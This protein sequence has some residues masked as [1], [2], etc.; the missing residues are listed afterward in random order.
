MSSASDS[1]LESGR[2]GEQQ[3]PEKREPSPPPRSP[4]L[5]MDLDSGLVGWE[6]PDDPL[7]PKNWPL[8][9]KWKT[10]I[11]II[12]SCFM[13]PMTSTMFAP[14]VGDVIAEFG[15]TSSLRQTLLIS[16]YVL[17]F[18]W[19]PMMLHAPLSEL[20]GRKYVILAS[21]FCFSM[22]NL[23]CSLSRTSSAF[24]ACR[25][26]GG[27]LGSAGMVVGGGAIS[28][29]FQREKIGKVSSAFALGPLM[30]PNL[31][32]II[33]GFMTENVG[34]RW[35]FRLLLILGVAVSLLF[36]VLA[37]ESNPSVLLHYKTKKL[38]KQLQRPELISVY[39]IN[40]K[41]THRQVFWFGISRPL[42][43]LCT[44]PSVTFL[45]LYTAIAFSFLYIFLTTVPRIYHD[46]Y[47]FSP[48]IVG[49]CYLGMGA[50]QLAGIL[51]VGN[52]NDKLVNYLTK[53]NGGKR[54]PEFRLRPLFLSCIL[55]PVSMFWYG[56]AVEYRVHW[57]AVVASMFPLGLGMVAS[58]IPIQTYLIEAYAPFGLAA[59]ATAAGNC[60]RMT[61]GAFFPLVSAPLFNSLGHGWGCSLLGFL[62]LGLCGAM[63]IGFVYFGK[64]LR[65]RFP[66]RL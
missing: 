35:C 36:F 29:M 46:L 26:M 60:F 10:M 5:L 14:G 62:A 22:F 34:W 7:N 42:A 51:T 58:M 47:G 25:F 39:E 9:R 61:A 64:R 4:P 1:G 28:D 19:G 45:G 38:R 43:L 2:S 18:G 65:E 23:G 59:S 20:Y 55:L 13:L 52:T 8:S 15:E 12:V 30:G 3:D 44:C 32:P 54:E 63:A 17:G 24:L 40:N 33:G 57:F 37:E 48:G 31:G 16:I 27:F 49:L 53:K 6:S 11:L 50:G 21:N 66:P 56:W 41:R